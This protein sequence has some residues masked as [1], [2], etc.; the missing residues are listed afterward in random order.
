M[1]QAKQHAPGYPV[2][3]YYCGMVQ[4]SPKAMKHHRCKRPGA[5]LQAPQRTCPQCN[6]DHQ[7]IRLLSDMTGMVCLTCNH[8]FT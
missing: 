8:R 4:H 5:G 7:S 1:P 3:C 2:A 6:A